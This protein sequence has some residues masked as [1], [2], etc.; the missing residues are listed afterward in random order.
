MNCTCLFVLIAL[1]E[2]NG[3]R[4]ETCEQFWLR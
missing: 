4:L 3:S 1:P 2:T